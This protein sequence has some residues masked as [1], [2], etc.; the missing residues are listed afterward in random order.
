ME[1]TADITRRTLPAAARPR[2]AAVPVLRT[3]PRAPRSRSLA[4]GYVLSRTDDVTLFEADERLG[5]HAHTHD[6]R[7]APGPAHRAGGTD[8]L[9]R[10]N[11]PHHVGGERQ[12]RPAP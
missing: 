5:G 1:R 3:N 12:D 6:V 9:R 4:A 10:S 2:F 8:A 7:A 11:I